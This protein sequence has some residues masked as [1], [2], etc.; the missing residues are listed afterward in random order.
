LFEQGSG[1]EKAAKYL[2][3]GAERRRGRSQKVLAGARFSDFFMIL[4]WPENTAKRV[5]DGHDIACLRG[6]DSA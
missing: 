6:A 4:D 3:L 5:G 2:G 1:F